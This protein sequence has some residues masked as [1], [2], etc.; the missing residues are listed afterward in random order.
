M[1]L[2]VTENQFKKIVENK[3][4]KFKQKILE[5]A[6]VI[7]IYNAARE[8]GMNTN[9]F[10]ERFNLELNDSR[11]T[12]LVDFYM[13][14]RFD[15]IYNFIEKGSLCTHYGTSETFLNVVIE[16]I[17]E[18]CYNNFNFTSHLDIDEEDIEFENI[19]YQMEYYIIKNY[20]DRIKNK[21]NEICLG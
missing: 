8:L 18:F 19:F 10:I 21:F 5:R 15:K 9:E 16:T 2:I 17:N 12:D 20:E 3:L 7:G 4:E 1:K 11:I 6:K 13:E 14:N